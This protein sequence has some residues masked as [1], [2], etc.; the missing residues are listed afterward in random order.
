MTADAWPDL[1]YEGWADTRETLHLWS[2]IVG[3]I[4]LALCPYRNQWWQV[5][6][7]LT[8]RGL[9]TGLIPWRDESFQIDLDLVDSRLVVHTSS[10]EQ[11][12]LALEPRTVADFHAVLFELLHSL[13][14]EPTI[15]T[16]PSE[17]ANAIPFDEDTV[18]SAF[19]AEAARRWW[20]A[21]LSI[22]RAMQRF[23]TPFHGKS[24]PVH[25]FWGGL[26]LNCTR[27]N[28]R[29]APANVAD[30]VIRQYA[31]DQ[32]NF[33]FGF[34]PGSDDFPRAL[35]YAY[36][37]PA[38]EG[39]GDATVEPAEARYD[40]ALGEFVL[41][42]DHIRSAGSPDDAIERFLQTTYEA[43][44]EL[45]GWDRPALEGHIP[46]RSRRA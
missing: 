32:E 15:S 17:L 30:D 10:G 20:R 28:G 6:L 16:R 24:S 31:E 37:F 33:S 44:V 34:W 35:L 22:E 25:L 21:T 8:A 3:K 19:D 45:A 4:K 23:Q 7:L 41:L 29:S 18:H 26:D 39:I 2:Q 42:Y 40:A 38:P 9:T 12:S 5:S 27:F 14:I 36:I 46:A 43:S 11:R 13:G 1:A